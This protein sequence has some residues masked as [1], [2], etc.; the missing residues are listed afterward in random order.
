MRI[1][2]L[3]HGMNADTNR[4]WRKAPPTVLRFAGMLWLSLNHPSLLHDRTETSTV[5]ALEP[6]A[7]SRT[8]RAGSAPWGYPQRGLGAPMNGPCQRAHRRAE[9]GRPRCG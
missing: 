6:A 7:V 8:V 1:K 5:F 4:R 2:N 9:R 3:V